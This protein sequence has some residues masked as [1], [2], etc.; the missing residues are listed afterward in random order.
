MINDTVMQDICGRLGTNFFFLCSIEF[1]SRQYSFVGVEGALT[2]LLK[3][4]FKPNLVQTI[5]GTPAIIHGGPF[6]NIAHGCNSLIATNTARRLVGVVVTEVGF[7]ADLG[8]EKFMHIKSRKGNFHPDA[9]VI[10]A[11]IRALT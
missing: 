10:V 7:G 6:A 4:A 2:L 8:A 5:E 3:D 1:T 11:T 9:V